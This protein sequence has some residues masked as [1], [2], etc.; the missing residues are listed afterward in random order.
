M[1]PSSAG[2]DTT[3]PPTDGLR[4]EDLRRAVEIYLTHAYP[5]REIPAAVRKRLE[6][7][8]DVSATEILGGP[9]FEKVGKA[10]P[11]GATIHALRL[12]NARYPHMKLQIQPWAGPSGFLLSVNTHDQVLALDPN[13]PDAAAFRT[14][15]AE[16][17][18]YKQAIEQAWDE[19]GLPIFLRYLRE[20]IRS[21]TGE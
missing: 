13:S 11:D 19:A 18:K 20:Y 9:P 16:N 1:P 21:N 4:L 15:Q 14:L 10:G 17:Q 3:P 7:P 2:S 8:S 5:N 6:W 12:G